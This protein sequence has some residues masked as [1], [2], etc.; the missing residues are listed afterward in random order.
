MPCWWIQSN[1]TTCPA[2]SSG[3]AVYV[4]RSMPPVAGTVV[5]VQC[6]INSQ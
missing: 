6:A 3:L 2:P 4:D 5:D 1:P